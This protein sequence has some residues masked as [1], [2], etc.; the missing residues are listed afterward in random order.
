M[1][2][3]RL[4]L[5]QGTVSL[6]DYAMD[7]SSIRCEVTDVKDEMSLPMLSCSYQMPSF[8]R[9]TQRRH[10]NVKRAGK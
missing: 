5:E 9:Q 3:T 4:T 1:Y 2:G 8:Q 7:F 10:A 6:D